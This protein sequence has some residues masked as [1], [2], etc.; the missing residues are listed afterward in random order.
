MSQADSVNSTDPSRISFSSVNAVPPR[1]YSSAGLVRACL[2]EP[3]PPI[4]IQLNFLNLIDN[5]VG[6]TDYADLEETADHLEAVLKDVTGYVKAVVS[7]LA[8]HANTFRP[9]RN[10]VSRRCRLRHRRRAPQQGQCARGRR[11]RLVRRAVSEPSH[12]GS[13]SLIPIPGP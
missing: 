12:G 3:R 13:F 7:N 4:G 1:R 5:I 10:R 11:G 9:R 2:A 6:V 8:Y